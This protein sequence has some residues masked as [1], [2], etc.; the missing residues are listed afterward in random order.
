MEQIDMVAR[1][2]DEPVGAIYTSL[3]EVIRV[4]DVSYV[5]T[6][7]RQRLLI[8]V[9]RDATRHYEYLAKAFAGLE[10]AEVIVD[11]RCGERR[12]SDRGHPLDPREGDRRRRRDVVARLREAPWAVVSV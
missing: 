8:I 11:R 7:W 10:W 5:L 3:G 4:L 6:Q 2:R 9:A 1:R 12:A